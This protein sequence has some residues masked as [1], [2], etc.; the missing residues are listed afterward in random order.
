MPAAIFKNLFNYLVYRTVT[1]HPFWDILAQ[2]IHISYQISL[3]LCIN[4]LSP[5]L[6]LPPL[7]VSA[8]WVVLPP[9]AAPPAPA[10][11]TLQ[12]P[13][14]TSGPV[15][16]TVWPPNCSVSTV[17]PAGSQR[18]TSPCH[19]WPARRHPLL[20][21]APPSARRPRCLATPWPNPP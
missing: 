10:S 4:V 2:T 5:P 15:P 8:Q 14:V 17:L 3:C 20:K 12:R 21:A 13:Q 11:P 1:V 9:R 7:S 19:H 6:S 16:S 18:G